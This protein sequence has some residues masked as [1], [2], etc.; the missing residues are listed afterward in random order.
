MNNETHTSRYT[1]YLA[2]FTVGILSIP[3]IAMQFTQEVAWTLFDFIF[4]G[5]LIFGTGMT[6]K[7]IT[8]NSNNWVFRAAVAIALGSGFLLIWSNAAVGIIGSENND[9]NLLFYLVILVGLIGIFLSRLKPKGLAF[10]MIAMA[11][12]HAFITLF[13]LIT[14]MN[15]VPHSSVFEILGIN[16]FFITLYLLSAILFY[17]AI[18]KPNNNIAETVE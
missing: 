1:I 3:L 15:K 18:K 10:T 13:A 5:L 2:L 8:Y 4:A 16:G 14:G 11:I 17:N 6:F 12:T 7:I 9:F